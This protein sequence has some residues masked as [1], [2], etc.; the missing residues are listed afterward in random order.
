MG[1]EVEEEDMGKE[2]END[3]E[4][5]SEEMEEK[6]EVAEVKEVDKE[7]KVNVIRKWSR[8]EDDREVHFKIVLTVLGF[9]NTFFYTV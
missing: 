2:V 7:T 5:M 3:E 6:L 4:E 1:K 8:M 9:K